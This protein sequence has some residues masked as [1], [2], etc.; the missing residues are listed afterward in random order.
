MC[1]PQIVNFLFLLAFGNRIWLKILLII[2]LQYFLII[3]IRK[4][5]RETPK[6]LCHILQCP[7][8]RCANTFPKTTPI[9]F[10]PSSWVKFWC[11]RWNGHMIGKRPRVSGKK[12]SLFPHDRFI[13]RASVIVTQKK[14]FLKIDLNVLH[15]YPST[16]TFMD[17]FWICI[18]AL[19]WGA[20]NPFIKK[21]S[22]GMG[23]L[24]QQFWSRQVFAP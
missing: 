11:F 3:R 24:L 12:G 8:R 4:E 6:L 2:F 15:V 17:L 18:C 20:T 21:G 10:F 22:S 13:A 9:A 5:G 1:D 14:S 16:Q 23:V 19:L 7:T